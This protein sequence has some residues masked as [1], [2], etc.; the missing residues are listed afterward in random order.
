MSEINSA[1]WELLEQ[2]NDELMKGYGGQSRRQ[3]FQ[4]FD[5]P[6]LH[7]LPAERFQITAVHP[8]MLV[9][10][11]YHVLYGKHH[12]SVPYALVGHCVSS[13][14]TPATSQGN[15]TTSAPQACCTLMGKNDN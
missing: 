4:Q 2:F 10:R 8:N 5:L 15:S 14:P 6:A 3:R 12:Y 1:V 7:P 13:T 11:N 9:A